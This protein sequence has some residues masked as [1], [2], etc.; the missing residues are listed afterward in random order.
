MNRE[1]ILLRHYVAAFNEQQTLEDENPHTITVDQAKSDA[2]FL[3][4]LHIWSDDYLRSKLLT[5]LTAQ[6]EIRR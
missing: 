4:W 3:Y 1:Q 5:I 2:H 6:Q